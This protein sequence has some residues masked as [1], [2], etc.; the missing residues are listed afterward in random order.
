[1][2]NT[3]VDNFFEHN[4]A[5]VVENGTTLVFIFNYIIIPVQI[6]KEVRQEYEDKQQSLT[7]KLV[8]DFEKKSSEKQ[9]ELQQCRQQLRTAQQQ[10][11]EARSRD[12]EE[13]DG[14]RDELVTLRGNVFELLKTL[15][16]SDDQE[17]DLDAS[18][19][20]SHQVDDM[21]KQVLDDT[22]DNSQ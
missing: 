7:R 21:V 6:M 5:E 13:N 17:F 20:Q 8:E 4:F 14:S 3:F 12:V 22:E 18:D 16:T 15:F 10:L 9:T 11:T 2:Y 19:A 1:M